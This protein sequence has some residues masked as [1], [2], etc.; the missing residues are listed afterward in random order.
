MQ[1]EVEVSDISDMLLMSDHLFHPGVQQCSFHIT[2][3][4]I[5]QC[6]NALATLEGCEVHF[7]ML[8][9]EEEF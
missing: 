6:I 2:L 5:K 8:V 1:Q 3:Q 9:F 4:E 7:E